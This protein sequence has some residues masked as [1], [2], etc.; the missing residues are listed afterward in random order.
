MKEGQRVILVGVDGSSESELAFRAALDHARGRDAKVHVLS[1][2]GGY[3]PFEKLEAAMDA[4][5]LNLDRER[6]DL[7]KLVSEWG[8]RWTE[9][10]GASAPPLEVEVRAGA[11]ARE[12]LRAAKVLDAELIA[13][14]THGRS[15]LKRL[16][17]G[18]VAEAVLRDAPCPVLVVRA[19]TPPSAQS[20]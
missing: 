8:R 13:V 20:E 14:G 19:A 16:V 9:A 11:P 3:D 17:L 2:L 12:I 4:R 1:A 15:G 10:T 7:S 6:A 18:S 5:Q